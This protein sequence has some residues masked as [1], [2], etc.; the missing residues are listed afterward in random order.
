MRPTEKPAAQA[1]DQPPAPPL[2]ELPAKW[3]AEAARI[4]SF[5]AT[6]SR[7]WKQCADELEAALLSARSPV[8]P[9]EH[10]WCEACGIVARLERDYMPADGV[11]NMHAATDLLCGECRTIV[12]TL[13]H[14]ADKREASPAVSTAKEDD[15]E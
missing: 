10:I 1:A 13:H 4:D 15:Q 7:G 3:R 9:A 5:H 11:H 14:L 2:A 12:A 6:M 8:S